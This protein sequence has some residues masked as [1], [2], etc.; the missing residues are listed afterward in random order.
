MNGNII[1]QWGICLQLLVR[2]ATD[3]MQ[4]DNFLCLQRAAILLSHCISLHKLKYDDL[5]LCVMYMMGSYTLCVNIKIHT[6]IQNLYIYIYLHMYIYIC[7]YIYIYTYVLY[8][9][10]SHTN[11][12][13]IYVDYILYNIIVGGWSRKCW[14]HPIC[15]RIPTAQS[16]IF[17]NGL[18]V[19]ETTYWMKCESI[20]TCIYI[21]MYIL[22]ILYVF[23]TRT[24][25]WFNF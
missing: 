6:Y 21:Y 16:P 1:Y 15:I 20:Y 19:L 10:Y 8:M 4:S 9:W 3:L 7:I 18:K 5:M 23:F 12:N 2:S 11:I 22:Y 17:W 13:F 25:I 24:N 14:I